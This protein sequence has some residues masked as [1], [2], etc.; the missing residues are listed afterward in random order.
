[1]ARYKNSIVWTPL[2]VITWF[3]PII[4]H[5]GIT[6]D[7]GIIYDFGGSNYIA[8]DNFTF[9]KPTKILNLDPTKA[10]SCSWNEAIQISAN[11]FRQ[12]THNIVTNNCHDHVADTL[13]EMNYNDRSNYKSIDIWLMMT[14]HS[15]YVGLRG[16][17]LQWLPFITIVCLLVILITLVF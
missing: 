5:T 13:N 12:R 16:F 10:R 8:V 3:V 9:G 17:L 7:Q 15:E 11:R 6:D 2:P 14:L 1:M 4:G